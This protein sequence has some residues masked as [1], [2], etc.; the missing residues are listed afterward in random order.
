M[1]LVVPPSRRFLRPDGLLDTSS[2]SAEPCLTVS[3]PHRTRQQA[4]NHGGAASLQPARRR[5]VPN[6]R[7]NELQ[8]PGGTSSVNLLS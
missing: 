6:C 8:Q 2:L 1:G 7:S 5:L 3:A 4:T